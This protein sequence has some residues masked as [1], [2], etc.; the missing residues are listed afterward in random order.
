MKRKAISGIMLAPLLIGMLTLAFSTSQ[1]K[2]E[3]KTRIVDDDGPADF[4]TIQEA[5]N[6]AYPGDTINVKAGIY[7]ENII[8]NKSISLIGADNVN[9][10][11]NGAKG[12]NVIE[13]SDE[14]NN[15]TI[16]GFTLEDG[17]YGVYAYPRSW[18]NTIEDNRVLN[19]T[20]G[21]F[22]SGSGNRI[23]RNFIMDASRG[24]MVHYCNNY[25][26]SNEIIGNQAEFSIGVDLTSG[27]WT[28]CKENEVVGNNVT[29]FRWAVGLYTSDTQ[30][31]IYNNR[32][33]HNNFMNYTQNVNIFRG[34][35]D[36]SWDDGYP[37]G[38]N[39]WSDYTGVDLY[40]SPYQN[41]TGSD[42]IGDTVYVIK[43]GNQDN[44]PLMGMYYDF[45]VLAP[46][47]QKTYHIEVISNST[48]SNLGIYVWLSSPTQYLQPG[49]QFILFFVSGVE[50]TTGFCRIT[51]PRSVINDTYVVLLDGEEVPANELIASNTTHAYL[52]FSY[53]H[54]THEVIIVPEFP[55]AMILSLFT[56]LAT[57]AVVSVK[58]KRNC[59]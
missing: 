25:V 5:I 52:Y 44:Y 49:Q 53:K 46:Y 48:V 2:S 22:V 27:G 56:I 1:F 8:V 40:S 24:V 29:G 57:L 59:S 36:N 20:Y 9:T 31:P 4:Y 58:R 38:G 15:V 14:V 51:I 23:Q 7:Y 16:S 50:N 11:I 30:R 45:E 42:G 3:P 17:S 54:T 33:Y 39:Y 34:V 55:S 26:V 12:S 43:E 6:A 37:S 21:I 28:Q 19:C 18:N 47:D 41:E 10:V 13:I 32:F 35:Y